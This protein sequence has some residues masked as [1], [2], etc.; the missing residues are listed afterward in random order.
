[1]KQK[2]LKFMLK[3][4]S[5]LAI[6]LGMAILIGITRP[7]PAHASTGLNSIGFS[8]ALTLA[9]IDP[10]FDPANVRL[11][12]TPTGW[13][14]SDD[15]TIDLDPPISDKQIMSEIALSEFKG[16]QGAPKF[17]KDVAVLKQD[18]E[19]RGLTISEPWVGTFFTIG[20]ADESYRILDE[21][22]AF[23]NNFDS[24][25]IVVAEL[26][27]A[28]HQQPID[29]LTNRP[30]LTDARWKQL[31]DGL[32]ELGRRAN[33]AGKVLCYHPH[34]GTAV[35]TVADID[36]LMTNT[37]PNSVHLLLDTGH[38]SY[39]MA[40][41]YP[42]VDIFGLPLEVAKKYRDR[43]KHVHMKNIREDKLTNAVNSEKSF[44]S[45]IRDG[46]FTVPGDIATGAIDFEP[47][48]QELAN[49]NYQ[50]WLMVEA[51]QDPNTTMT[52]YGMESLE[53]ALM[54]RGYLR[55]V[56]GL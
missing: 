4:I 31:T 23:M 41:E 45:A 40:L 5:R 52:D 7:L 14:N 32:N 20:A 34:V 17:P 15:L 1:M 43:I 10:T 25:I 49:A 38:I 27:E 47:I 6:S 50:G 46:V 29:P 24:N 28:V 54:A 9:L 11:G 18:L 51:E 55:E 53:Y 2:E 12:I 21:Q 37:D 36:R 19:T 42:G 8:S 22:I 3:Q 26:G 30:I 13:S 44:L 16:T 39:A 48:L 33:A 35:A 56:T